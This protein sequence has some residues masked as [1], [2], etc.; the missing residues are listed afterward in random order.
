MDA[1][2]LGLLDQRLAALENARYQQMYNNQY[3]SWYNGIGNQ[4]TDNADLAH[5]LFNTLLEQFDAGEI[6]EINQDVTSKLIEG[7]SNDLKALQGMLKQNARMIEDTVDA[8]KAEVDDV[9]NAVSSTNKAN[10]Q[11]ADAQLDQE[12]A[13]ISLDDYAA[14]PADLTQ[15]DPDF[16]QA[17]MDQPAMP[18]EAPADI[19]MEQA[20]MPAEAPADIPMDLP[21][22]QA[23]S[24]ATQKDI[25]K[26][27]INSRFRN[28]ISDIRQKRNLKDISNK[29][30]EPEKPAGNLIP[31]SILSACMQ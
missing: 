8:L 14:M 16:A 2:E 9:T 20:P 27:M 22:Q 17:P 1:T 10:Q 26:P 15:G 3:D 29:P 18:V 30:K 5:L 31:R 7:L 12:L 28:I 4:Y 6:E 24:D 25:I 23:V 13:N 19:P 11:A 21:P